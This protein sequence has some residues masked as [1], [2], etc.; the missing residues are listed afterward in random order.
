MYGNVIIRDGV[1]IGGNLTV[2]G[3][4]TTVNSEEVLV[5]DNILTLNSNLSGSPPAFLE[6]GIQVYRGPFDDP[7]LFTFNEDIQTFVVGLCGISG[8]DRQAVATRT[9]LVD[10]NLAYWDDINSTFKDS[11]IAYTSLDS[12]TGGTVFR[13]DS[14]DT[15]SGFFTDKIKEGTNIT[16]TTVPSSGPGNKEIF[17]NANFDPNGVFGD[18]EI[19]INDDTIRIDYPEALTEAGTPIISLVIPIS[20]DFLQITGIYNSNTTGFNVQLSS[21]VRSSGYKINWTLNTS[22]QFDLGSVG[23]SIVP[24]ADVTY[25]LGSPTNRWR[26]LY[27]DGSTLY[28]GSETISV[29]ESISGNENQISFSGNELVV[30]DEEGS[31]PLSALPTEINSGLQFIDTIDPVTSF[32]PNVSGYSVGSY[33]IAISGGTLTDSI[34]ASFSVSEG[35]WALSNGTTWRKMPFKLPVRGITSAQIKVGGIQSDNI[36]PGSVTNAKLANGS[37][38]IGKIDPNVLNVDNFNTSESNV[39][40]VLR[41]DGLGGT[42]WGFVNTDVANLDGRVTDLENDKL[43]TSLFASLSGGGDVD[44]TTLASV[45]GNLQEQIDERPKKYVQTLGTDNP[46]IV[47]HNLGTRN[48]TYSILNTSTYALIDAEVSVPTMNTMRLQ[49]TTP[50]ISGQYEVTV[51]G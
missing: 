22:S 17:I 8:D 10:G 45:S 44:T 30:L 19:P 36:F 15:T 14:E 20:G 23:Q 24:I 4:T 21:P 46:A 11:G 39:N 33:F 43:D 41:P 16:F 32:L 34:S 37:V 40:K 12:I 7:Y 51:I 3:T 18:K 2:Q 9:N 1:E 13:I 38:T 26:D 28:I 6:S 49:F 29:V 42:Q 47:T 25:D 31:L 35:D 27:L 48:L 5:E 50:P